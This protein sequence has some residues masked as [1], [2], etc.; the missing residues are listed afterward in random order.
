MQT[1]H[2][3]QSWK[4]I[5]VLIFTFSLA[6][7]LAVAEEPP[8]RREI[9]TDLQPLEE[10]PPPTISADENPDEPQI[11]IIK[12]KGETVEEYRINGQLYM[13][14]VTPEHGVPYYLHKEDQD[15]GWVNIG[16]NPPLIIPKWTIFT[17]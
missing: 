17:F 15:G 4:R 7:V 5:G 3:S 11:T 6:P 14:K 1:S 8:A 10:I 13:M 2:Q 9:P 12:K 16:P